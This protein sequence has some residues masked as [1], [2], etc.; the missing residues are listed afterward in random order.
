MSSATVVLLSEFITVLQN[1]V[2]ASSG[3]SG[4]YAG[5]CVFVIGLSLG[6]VDSL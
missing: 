1:L 2:V 5:G 3:L 4:V 6:C